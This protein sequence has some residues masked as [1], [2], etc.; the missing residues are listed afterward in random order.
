M[1]SFTLGAVELTLILDA[2]GT[3]DGN[4]VFHPAPQEVWSVGLDPDPQGNVAM[5]VTGLLISEGERHTLVDTGY[6][7][8]E[9]PEREESILKGLGALGIQPKEIGCVILT[10]SHGDHCLGNTL[11][12]AGRWLAAFPLAEYVV[13][14]S[15][16]SGLRTSHDPVWRTRF[17]PLA[18]RGQLRLIEGSVRLTD[19]VACWPTPG[20][21]TGHQAVR[22]ASKGKQALF[23]GDLAILAQNMEHPE[24]GPDWAWSKEVDRESR[25]QVAEWAV[26]NDALL[27]V[28]HDPT[29]PWIRLARAGA[30]YRAL[31]LKE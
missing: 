19:S 17:L 21:T 28:G 2:H 9:R 22:I 12:R 31:P 5:V 23:V 4:Q 10:H 8:E 27:I 13:Q 29:H 14:E 30:G 3:I 18:E 1:Q 20:H 11:N 26:D 7:E 24:W 16:I 15:E 6:G 25:Q